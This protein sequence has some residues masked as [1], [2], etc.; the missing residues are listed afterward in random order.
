MLIIAEI[1]LSQIARFHQRA[2]AN[3]VASATTSGLLME[4]PFC[5]AGKP[6]HRVWLPKRA[7]LDFP[8]EDDSWRH[9]L[10]HAGV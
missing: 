9:V 2:A 8:D 7:A 3:C 10:Q 1:A 4:L 5:A 6:R